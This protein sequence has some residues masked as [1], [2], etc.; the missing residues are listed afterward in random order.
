M[1]TSRTGVLLL[2][3][4]FRGVFEK[5]GRFEK[6]DGEE[7]SSDEVIVKR[8]GKG[9]EE[10]SI[11]PLLLGAMFFPTSCICLSLTIVGG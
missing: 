11:N 4:S 10:G 1:V 3:R 7:G 8:F 2:M 6:G 5:R 9:F